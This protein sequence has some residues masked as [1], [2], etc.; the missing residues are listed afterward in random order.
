MINIQSSTVAFF[1]NKV[2]ILR[3]RPSIRAFAS[4]QVKRLK[5]A[6]L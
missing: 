1:S 5:N 2:N 6:V 3:T 4:F